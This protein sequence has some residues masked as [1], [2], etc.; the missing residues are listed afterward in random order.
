MH[1]SGPIELMLRFYTYPI[2]TIYSTVTD[3]A[4]FLG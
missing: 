2:F 1:K 3:L 4:R